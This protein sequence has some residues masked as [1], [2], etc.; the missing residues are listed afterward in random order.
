MR[1]SRISASTTRGSEA[2]PDSGGVAQQVIELSAEALRLTLRVRAGDTAMPVALGWHPWLARDGGEQTIEGTGLLARCFEHEM[3]HLDGRVFVDHLRLAADE[4]D[5][6][7]PMR[8]RWSIMS[9]RHEPISASC[10]VALQPTT[11]LL[12]P[13]SVD[14]VVVVGGIHS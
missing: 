8:V 4:G 7:R 1:M 14:Y 11:A 2:I 10:G 3:D 13:D 12:A 5:R 6:S 9:A